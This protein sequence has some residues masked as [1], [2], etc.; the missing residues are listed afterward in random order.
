MLSNDKPNESQTKA[1]KVPHADR[2]SCV[3]DSALNLLHTL[4]HFRACVF[5]SVYKANKSL[6]H[7]LMSPGKMRSGLHLWPTA[8]RTP[9]PALRFPSPVSPPRKSGCD[10]Q[11]AVAGQPSISPRSYQ[12]PFPTWLMSFAMTPGWGSPQI[13]SEPWRHT[14]ASGVVVLSGVFCCTEFCK[15]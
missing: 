1:F 12:Q 7:C 5:A 8:L 14:R 3:F 6:T 15:N 13:S 10:F 4:S 9:Q 11:P 2:G